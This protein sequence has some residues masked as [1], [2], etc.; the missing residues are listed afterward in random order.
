VPHVLKLAGAAGFAL[1]CLISFALIRAFVVCFGV[2]C[3]DGKMM[4]GNDS[5]SYLFSDE[6][7][8]ITAKALH[9]REYPNVGHP[10]LTAS[11]LH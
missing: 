1:G 8:F 9:R 6:H 7:C 11:V 4:A 5:A 10:G 3:L 2:S